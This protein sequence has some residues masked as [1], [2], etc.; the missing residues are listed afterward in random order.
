MMAKIDVPFPECQE[1]MVLLGV[2]C[3]EKQKNLKD[4][5]GILQE[6]D[7]MVEGERVPSLPPPEV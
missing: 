2:N 5:N 6:L 1:I 4:Q 3:W 7:S